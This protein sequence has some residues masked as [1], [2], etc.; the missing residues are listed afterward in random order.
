MNNALVEHLDTIAK[1]KA[2][3]GA[4]H[5]SV[6]SYERASKAVRDANHEVAAQE[7]AAMP[8]VG[9]KIAL[10]V[11]EFLTTGTSSTYKELV[12]IVPV[13][14][15]T[16]TKVQGVGAKKAYKLWQLGIK[17]LD[18]LV[19][20]AESN[21]L[22]D[23]AAA[24]IG[25]GSA[26]DFRKA[27]LF[28]RDTA[29]G[30]L[31]YSTAKMV[32]DAVIAPL[33]ISRPKQVELLGS[34][35][36]KQDTI[37]DIDVGICAES[38]SS[39]TFQGIFALLRTCHV[40]FDV[41]TQGDTKASLRVNHFGIT[42]ACDIWLVEKWYWGSFL[43][44]ATGSKQHNIRLRGLALN[45]GLTINEYGIFE[46]KTENAYKDKIRKNKAGRVT[47]VAGMGERLGGEFETDVYR[48][49]GIDY[50]EPEKRSE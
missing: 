23:V 17:T 46:L 26:E 4:N 24:R 5:F 18:D 22:A 39:K 42:M 30:R 34:L 28:A 48:M 9:A 29:A 36:R 13:E 49:L 31:P 44:Y 20:R 35:R 16:M 12:K 1:L 25:I 3:S 27:I 41:V 33:L 37:K 47:F 6:V 15:L 38:F 7:V 14:C 2:L 8:G 10:T 45:K 11:A 40:D 21:K 50:V 32:G 43:N 19:K